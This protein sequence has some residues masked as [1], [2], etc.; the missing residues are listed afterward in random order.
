MKN[1]RTNLVDQ[2]ELDNNNYEVST[3][4]RLGY[5]FTEKQKQTYRN[6]CTSTKLNQK[7]HDKLIAIMKHLNKATKSE[8]I[9]ELINNYAGGL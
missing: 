7:E 8:T 6:I 2:V 5:R 1:I 3:Y 4:K 9:R